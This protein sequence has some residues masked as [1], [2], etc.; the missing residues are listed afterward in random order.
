MAY[1]VGSASVEIIPDFRNAQNAITA[2]FAKQQNELRVP[3]KPDI[4]PEAER[5]VEQ[6]ARRT[7]TKVGKAMADAAEKQAEASRQ[8]ELRA[9]ERLGEAMARDVAKA[10]AKAIADKAKQQEKADADALAAQQRLGAAMAR[11]YD[12]A[13]TERQRADAAALRETQRAIAER[14]K[15]EERASAEIAKIREREQKEQERLGAQM[16]RE[17]ERAI[18]AR[19]RAEQKAAD[20]AARDRVKNFAAEERLFQ[21]QLKAQLRSM[22]AAIREASADEKIRLQI[23]I[24][25]KQAIL[26]GRTTGG[27][28]ARAITQ[29]FKQNAGLITAA[30]TGAL[31]VGAGAIG[32]AAIGAFAGIGAAGAFQ[33]EYLKGV[34]R[35]TFT[36]IRDKGISDTAVLIPA[37]ENM[38]VK[39]GASFERM[40]PQ[41]RAAFADLGPQIGIFTDSLTQMAENALPGLV[42]VIRNGTPIIS[43]F[44]NLM[45]SVGQGTSDLFDAVADH[46]PAAGQSLTALG[47]GFGE[48]LPLLG[49]LVG[50]GAEL[51]TIVLPV[52]TSALGGM[53]TVVD[54]LGG[55]LP[56]LATGFLAF[57]A[58]QGVG[59]F[60]NQASQAM[61][62]A[63]PRFGVFAE[64]L[65]GSAVAGE[66]V[67]TGMGRAASGVAAIGRALPIAGIAIAGIAAIMADA[68]LEIDGFAQA[69]V[70]GGA[71]AAKARDDL[72]DEGAWTTIKTGI[73]GIFDADMWKGASTAEIRMKNT[74]EAVR[75]LEASMS[76]LELAQSR[77]AGWT[78][79]LAFRL[80]DETSSAEDVAIAQRKVAEYSAKAAAE[81]ETLERGIRGVTS[82]MNDQADAARARVD[83]EFGYQQAIL[84]TQD[85]AIKVTEAQTALNEARASGDIEAIKQAELD[86]AQ[87][88]LDSNSALG[89][90][91]AAAKARAESNLPASL[92]EEQRA[93]LGNKAA[94]QEL[95]NMMAMGI[96]LPPSLEQ[97]RQFLQGAV[98]DAD[99]AKI[100]QAQLTAAIGEVGGAVSAIPDSKAVQI[101][102]PTE[103]LITRLRDLGFTIEQVPGTKDVIVSADTEEAKG[104]LGNLSGLLQDV[105]DIRVEPSAG[106]FIGPLTAEQEKARRL[107]AQLDA[108]NPEPVADMFIGPLLNESDRAGRSVRELAGQRPTP[109]AGLNPGPFNAGAAGVLGGVRNLDGQ[110]P[111]PVAGLNAGPFNGGAA[112]VLAQTR[113]LGGQRPT[114]TVGLNDQ[115]TGMAR[116]IQAV[117]D[118]MRG[119]TITITTLQQNRQVTGAFAADGGAVESLT[120]RPLSP[121]YKFDGGGAVYGRGGPRDDLIPA[122]G[123]N[124]NAQYK[125]ANGEHILD[126]RDVA[127]MGGQAGVYAFREMLNA[128]AFSGPG[129]DTSITQM[130]AASGGQSAGASSTRSS[131]PVRD[132]SI[133]TPDVPAAI[134]GLKA[135]E[136]ADA[137]LASPWP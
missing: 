20:D 12:R 36:D 44:G 23:E 69:F 11:D 103:D 57:R 123:P 56:V 87:A 49:E 3:V 75:E 122:I 47:D 107:L 42:N 22:K 38:A 100:A 60:V 71:A 134:R 32:A 112:G 73:A 10:T 114:P 72:A 129:A 29:E 118:G 1:I 16:A 46:A 120:M 61:L 86:F 126:G 18:A 48:L 91:V 5:A 4:T 51:G 76:P 137:V 30:V 119:K 14:V 13:L 136:H 101:T 83:T 131:A 58:V 133:Y 84:D 102:A 121:I 81:Q 99:G 24:D 135:V 117:I 15:A 94:L 127:L 68:K 63:A 33:S 93:F 96:V 50:E 31:T 110:R 74:R 82:A 66:R 59:R 89:D 17:V 53:R 62:D 130:V 54:A 40:R 37:F 7:G 116:R 26:D 52:L 132:V 128:G 65:T 115:A 35:D 25:E 95:N 88:V 78:E 2:F 64:G 113:V 92:D 21:A 41:L 106:L 124:P 28:V 34:W 109:V 80:Q 105:D 77:L 67:M 111:T 85:A 19:A 104:N 79:T 27:V 125:I 45:E 90:Q 9:Q 8:R 98:Q 6:Q 108:D 55:S 43:G 70:K 97:Y 39:I